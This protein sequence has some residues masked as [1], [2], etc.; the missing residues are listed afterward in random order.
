MDVLSLVSQ[1]SSP[2]EARAPRRL[3][4]LWAAVME[5]S[6]VPGP[7]R[8]T[9]G[10]GAGRPEWATVQ[11]GRPAPPLPA[12][13][14]DYRAERARAAMVT[15]QNVSRAL[16]AYVKAQAATGG[17][18]GAPGGVG[19]ALSRAARHVDSGRPRTGPM[20]SV[21]FVEPPATTGKLFGDRGPLQVKP[22]RDKPRVLVDTGKTESLSEAMLRSTGAEM[23]GKPETSE[24]ARHR[25]ASQTEEDLSPEEIEQIAEEVITMLRRESEFDRL[26]L[27]DDEWD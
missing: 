14:P 8:P 17:R 11:M 3:A 22:P 18:V 7:S 21:S 27:G 13:D 25:L 4:A 16:V 2:V 10:G 15:P 12:S 26:R 1:A 5:A 23:G 24:K 19:D 20:S 9:A 6:A